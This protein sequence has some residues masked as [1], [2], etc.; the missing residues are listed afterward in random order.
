[1]TSVA[2]VTFLFNKIIDRHYLTTCEITR[3]CVG[4]LS[5]QKIVSDKLS[6][7]AIPNCHLL[8][9]KLRKQLSET[10]RVTQKSVTLRYFIKQWHVRQMSSMQLLILPISKPCDLQYRN[11]ACLR[12]NE[13]SDF[14]TFQLWKRRRVMINKCVISCLIRAIRELKHEKKTTKRKVYRSDS[15]HWRHPEFLF[16]FGTAGGADRRRPIRDFLRD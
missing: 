11:V 4:V 1:M 3:K 15:F 14:L 2:V 7:L 9:Q 5:S 12:Q 16:P 6:L 8:T 13:M 10:S